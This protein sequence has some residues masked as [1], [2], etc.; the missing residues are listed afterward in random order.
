MKYRPE[1]DGLRAV[2]V[3]PV[4]A[5][6]A[7]LP[8]LSGGYVGVD[9]FFVISG[10][11]I[12]G[13]L[14]GELQEGRFSVW[15]FYERR[16]RRILPA[17]FFVCSVSSVFA[18]LWMSPQQL[19]DYAKSLIAVVFSASNFVFWKEAGYFD[20]AAEL[21]PLLHTWSLAVEEHYYVVFPLCL[22]LLWRK[23]RSWALTSIV[24][25]AFVSLVLAQWGLSD[26]P[27]ARFYLAPSRV[28]EL[29]IG[30]ACAFCNVRASKLQGELLS[31]AGL[32]LIVGAVFTFEPATPGPGLYTLLPVSGTALVL[33]FARDSAFVANLLSTR[34]LVAIGLISYSAY[35]W[36]QPIF[37]FARIRSYSDP[38]PWIMS[39]LGLVAL[40]FAWGT[41]RFVEQPFRKR[42]FSLVSSRRSVFFATASAA[43]V[44][45]AFGIVGLVGDGLPFRLTPE[46]NRLSVAGSDKVKPTCRF[47]LR[48][49]LETHPAPGCLRPNGAGRASVLLLGDSHSHAISEAVGDLLATHQIGTYS[50]AFASCPAFRGLKR[51][52][53]T[54]EYNCDKFLSDALSFA[55]NQGIQTV[56]LTSR[57]A[58]YLRGAR[59]DNGEGGRELGGP[60]WVDLVSRAASDWDDPNRKGRV[61]SQIESDIRQLATEF[62]IVLVDPIPEAGWDVPLL[63]FKRAQFGRGGT[64]LSTKLDFYIEDTADIRALYEKLSSDLPT[65]RVAEVWKPL[66]DV[67]SGRCSNIDQRGVLY[68]DDDHLSKAGAKVVAPT[69]VEAIVAGFDS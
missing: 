36:H 26:K 24:A 23:G 6:H 41:W 32:A 33:L 17:L 65:V 15:S 45:A 8:W 39:G 47:E 25:A 27:A 1:I 30:S 44:I 14:L 68:F 64:G 63:G 31:S 11:L 60:A 7:G 13:I 38:G 57:I 28:W 51:F 34:L 52:D 5:F 43:A 55:R 50:A 10:Y 56:V 61:L 59:F 67:S 66:C 22:L 12:T 16:A 62:N 58:L 46:A 49:P 35:L 21:K 3:L 37:A 29:L 4:I 9:V 40:V 2:A 69:I 18:Y 19:E 48:K 54:Y 53:L 42:G 20:A